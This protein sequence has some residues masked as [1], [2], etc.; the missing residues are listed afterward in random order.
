[1]HV[2]IGR[3]HGWPTTQRMP[4]LTSGHILERGASVVC[5]TTFSRWPMRTRKIVEMTKLSA[6]ARIAYG[7]VSA[8][9]RPPDALGP[10]ICAT[11]TVTCSFELPSTSWSRS[12]RAGRYDWYATSKKT[13]KT[14]I[15]NCS[16]SRCHICSVWVAQRIGITARSTAREASPTIM[17]WRRRRRSTQTPA[18]SAKRMKGRKP[19]TPRS[20]NWNGLAW[21]P[22]AASQGIA[23]CEIC[24]PNSLIDWPAQSFLKSA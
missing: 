16:T 5:C 17:I 3:S 22:T 23:S 9:I 12:T 20:A 1:M 15:T 10:P 8:A 2:A 11:E 18:G 6:S 21:R 14:P 24:E 7:A 4:S 19:S 13:V